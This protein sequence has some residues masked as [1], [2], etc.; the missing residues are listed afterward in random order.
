VWSFRVHRSSVS[1]ALCAAAVKRAALL[2][3]CARIAVKLLREAQSTHPTQPTT[4]PTTMQQVFDIA[5]FRCSEYRFSAAEAAVQH[6]RREGFDAGALLHGAAGA[7][8]RSA[9]AQGASV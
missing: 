3:C 6:L 7:A 4:H 8:F 9:L 5:A 2:H 1:A